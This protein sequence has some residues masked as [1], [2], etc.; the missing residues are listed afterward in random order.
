MAPRATP[1]TAREEGGWGVNQAPPPSHP[2]PYTLSA[3]ISATTKRGCRP[4][5]SLLGTGKHGSRLFAARVA[6]V[7]KHNH[8]P[9]TPFA[10]SLQ[11][12]TS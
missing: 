8:P 1:R 7:R 5:V 6:P 11:A 4:W 2:R 12:G 3:Q 9:G 10:P